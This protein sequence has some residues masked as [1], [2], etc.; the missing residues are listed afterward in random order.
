MYREIFA[1]QSNLNRKIARMKSRKLTPSLD[2][3]FSPIEAANA[4]EMRGRARAGLPNS[5]CAIGADALRS[6]AIII[7]T[8]NQREETL[9]CL[10]SLAEASYQLSR[11]V[12]WDN[13]SV[14]GTEDAIKYEFSKIIF[15]RHPKNLGVAS[16]RNAAALLAVRELSPTHLLF[17]DNDMVVTPGF[18]ESLYEPLTEEPRLAQTAAKI[19]T[20][21]DPGRLN[22]AGGADVQF[23]QGTISPIGYGEVDIGQYDVRRPCLPNGGAT[24]VRVDIFLKL[25]GFDPV[26]DPYGP[27][28]LDFSYRVQQAGY[29]GLYVP[30]AVV[31][32]DH[33]R[34]VDGGYFGETYAANKTRHWMILMR[35]HASLPQQSGFYL[36]GAPVGFIRIVCREI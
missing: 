33:R 35:R 23:S 10:R 15:H 21:E 14:D 20:L 31:Y 28:D 11:I 5:Q 19:R 16:G 17:L 25:D 24:L 36:W 8:W 30:E 7:L 27:E 6:V 29:H 22:A 2:S 3:E 1:F 32:H 13:G 34:T 9:R 26:F 12:L 4:A 18:L